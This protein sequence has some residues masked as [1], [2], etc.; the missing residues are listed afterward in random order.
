MPMTET[1]HTHT[2][3]GKFELTPPIRSYAEEKFAKIDR[4]SIPIQKVQ[5]AYEVERYNQ[6]VTILVFASNHIRIRA[7]VTTK[8]MYASIDAVIGIIQSK[9]RKF[10]ELLKAHH[11][12][13]ASLKDPNHWT[14]EIEEINHSIEEQNEQARRDEMLPPVTFRSKR[15]LSMLLTEEAIMKMELSDDECMVYKDERTQELRAIYK[16]N[17]G[18]YG[19]HE[20]I[21]HSGERNS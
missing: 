13:S 1:T 9:F 8:D 11:L 7:S 16:R 5:F 2:A 20:V 6:T 10:H 3:K 12:K 17:D 21:P 18:T 4:F 14:D 19:V 15:P